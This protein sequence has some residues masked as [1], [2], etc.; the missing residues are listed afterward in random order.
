MI[1]RP[2]AQYLAEMAELTCRF[3][4]LA[5]ALRPVAGESDTMH[6]PVSVVRNL[7]RF[8]ESGLARLQKVAEYLPDEALAEIIAAGDRCSGAGDLDAHIPSNIP[9]ATEGRL[10]VLERQDDGDG[11]IFT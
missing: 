8:C 9:S 6:V 11:I 7:I 10:P 4:E 1:A 2:H 3:E 5:E